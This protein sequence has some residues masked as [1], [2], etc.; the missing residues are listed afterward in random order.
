MKE[1][2]LIP[3]GQKNRISKEKLAKELKTSVDKINPIIS[4]LRKQYVI[5]SDTKVGGYWRPDTKEELLEFIREHNSRQFAESGLIQMAWNE[6]D[7]LN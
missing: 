7:K 3:Y 2:D 5:L 6:I 4:Q 1:I